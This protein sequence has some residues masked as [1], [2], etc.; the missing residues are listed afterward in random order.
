MSCKV[1]RS[2]SHV[3]TKS[4]FDI[5]NIT[6]LVEKTVRNSGVTEGIVHVFTPHTTCGITVN[7]AE[8]GLMKDLVDFLSKHTEPGG[9]WMHN[10]IDDNAHAHLGQSM[11]GHH[12]TLPVANGSL[13]K[14]TWQSILLV[15]MDGPRTRKV[16]VTV[17]GI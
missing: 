14:G 8:P 2:Q 4:R 1:Y 3:P 13:V 5:V 11:I 7:E 16:I 17:M 9:S 15:E 12:A 10:R 6:N